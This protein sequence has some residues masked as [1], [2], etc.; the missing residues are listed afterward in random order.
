[1]LFHHGIGEFQLDGRAP[2]ENTIYRIASMSKSFCIAAVLVLRDRGLLSLDDRV[3]DLVPSSA[4]RS[5]TP[6]WCSP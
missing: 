2:A 6:A 4:T 1:M 5:T 3:S